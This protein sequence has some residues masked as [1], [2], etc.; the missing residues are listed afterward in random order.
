M[1]IFTYVYSQIKQE[2]LF[3]HVNRINV[4]YNVITN[5]IFVYFIQII[6]FH[7]KLQTGYTKDKHK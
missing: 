7:E 3:L 2:Y 4:Y 1:C 5:N 6:V